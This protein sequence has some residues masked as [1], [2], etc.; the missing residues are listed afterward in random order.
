MPHIP[1]SLSQVYKNIIKTLF[2]GILT[3]EARKN[4]HNKYF[5]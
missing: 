3:D 5:T 4:Y 1:Y 2:T